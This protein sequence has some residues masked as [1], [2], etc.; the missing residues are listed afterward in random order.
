MAKTGAVWSRHAIS[1]CS[2]IGHFEKQF[3]KQVT[4]ASKM[5]RIEPYARWS[6]L[7]A[8]Q[9]HAVVIRVFIASHHL[10]RGAQLVK[11]TA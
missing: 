6:S 5:D 4:G 3:V 7:R 11:Q 2:L 8:K 9:F 1:C 10:S